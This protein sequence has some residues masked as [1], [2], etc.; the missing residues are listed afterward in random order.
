MEEMNTAPSESRSTYNI[1]TLTGNY[2]DRIFIG[3]AMGRLAKEVQNSEGNFVNTPVA[4][5]N[6]REVRYRL[7]PRVSSVIGSPMTK[8]MVED[9]LPVGQTYV[10]GSATRTP[11]IV[12]LQTPS[13]AQLSCE[14]GEMYIRWDFGVIEANQVIAPIEYTTY[15]AATVSNGS[16]TNTAAITVD[17]DTSTLAQRSSEA[18]VILTSPAGVRISK[19]AAPTIEVNPNQ[20]QTAPRYATWQVAFTNLQSPGSLSNVDV[21]DVLP[22]NGLNNTSYHGS[23]TFEDAIVTTGTGVRILYTKQPDIATNTNPGDSRVYLPAEAVWCDAATEGAPVGAGSAED[24]PASKDEVTGLRYVRDGAFTS[25]DSFIVTVRM[26]PKG[27]VADDLYVNQAIGRAVGL[28][29][30][31][32]PVTSEIRAVGANVGDFVWVDENKNGRQDS[33][34]AGVSGVPV[35]LSGKDLDGNDIEFSTTTGED[36]VYHFS[37]LPASSRDG[38]SVSFDTSWIED[39]NYTITQ[40]FNGDDEAV[41]SDADPLTGRAAVVVPSAS[42]NATVDMGLIKNAPETPGGNPNNPGDTPDGTPGDTPDEETI[43]PGV[44]NTAKIITHS[45][46]ALAALALIGVGA[47]IVYRGQRS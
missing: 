44:P 19:T 18:T 43:I 25:Q 7:L 13:D 41:D 42:V 47:A 45:G 21:L 20:P 11:D 38:C 8:M 39:N 36:G 16:I 30:S 33:G 5:A 3:S 6:D 10:T 23:L 24:C 1:D 12:S 22:R 40:Q 46:I 15:I 34:E 4:Y 31:I 2:G 26:L 35:T 27:N 14:Q 28:S 17:G 32:G 9:C 29:Q 37:N